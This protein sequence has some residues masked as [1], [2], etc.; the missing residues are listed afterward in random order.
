MYQFV[1]RFTIFSIIVVILSYVATRFM[2][3]EH[4]SP[5]LPY[6]IIFF[7]AVTI[8]FQYFISKSNEKKF[9]NFVTIFMLITFLKLM[10]YF[11]VL[12]IYIFLINKSD[13]VPFIISFFIYYVLF[14]IFE[15]SYILMNPDKGK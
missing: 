13:S 10:L 12:L 6:L 2:L 7:F 5:A 1:K 15:V 3:P 9:S 4:V 11:T 8:I 14:T